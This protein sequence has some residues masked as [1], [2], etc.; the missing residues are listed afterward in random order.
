MS[1]YIFGT[2]ATRD[3]DEIWNFIA[4]DSADAADRW[5]EKLFG[6]FKTLWSAARDGL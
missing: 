3:L 4:K 2:G 1:S 5:L 6:A